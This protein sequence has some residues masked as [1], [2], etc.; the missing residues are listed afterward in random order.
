MRH[1][2]AVLIALLVMLPLIF[3]AGAQTS[4]TS[5]STSTTA[6]STAQ[7]AP[8]SPKSTT[9]TLPAETGLDTTQSIAAFL[10]DNWLPPTYAAPNQTALVG[11]NA[12]AANATANATA[13]A[14]AQFL[15]DSSIQNAYQ[16]PVNVAEQANKNGV[17]QQSG[18][19]ILDFLNDNWTPGMPG[20]QAQYVDLNSA[21]YS[22]HQMS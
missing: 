20:N 10:N 19:A 1:I 22:M 4:T 7:L 16:S 3:A 11:G 13:L 8:V 9:Q 15:A 6:A 12:T 21:G 2:V 18:Y 5:S 14:N 17:R